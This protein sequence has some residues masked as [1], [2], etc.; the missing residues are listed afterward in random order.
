M[1]VL[2][3][4]KVMVGGLGLRLASG[5]LSSNAGCVTIDSDKFDISVLDFL[6]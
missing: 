4:S 5:C 6:H 3:I 1:G 2:C